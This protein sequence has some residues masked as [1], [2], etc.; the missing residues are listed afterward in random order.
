MTTEELD[1]QADIVHHLAESFSAACQVM[2]ANNRHVIYALAIIYAN[3]E[4]DSVKASGEP[5]KRYLAMDFARAA[6]AMRELVTK[7]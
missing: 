1:H 4:R 7:E 5:G 2:K 6:E 3:L